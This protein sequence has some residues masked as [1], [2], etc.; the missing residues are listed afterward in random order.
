MAD[1][2]MYMRH[3]PNKRSR[4]HP[5]GD[6][7]NRKSALSIIANHAPRNH[8]YRQNAGHMAPRTQVTEDNYCTKPTSTAEY[9]LL[10]GPHH[11]PSHAV[12]TNRHSEH[13]Y[14]GRHRCAPTQLSGRL[15]AHLDHLGAAHTAH[16]Q[17]AG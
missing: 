13:T 11:T 4:T 3:F 16:R 1:T 17:G 8:C 10:P 5:K 9:S 2:D 7:P 15:M 14:R 12:A 6:V